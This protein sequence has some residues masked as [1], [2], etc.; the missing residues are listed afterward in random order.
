MGTV[1]DRND[2][3]ETA[4]KAGIRLFNVKQPT[5]IIPTTDVN[6][7]TNTITSAAHGLSAGDAIYYDNGGGGVMT[8]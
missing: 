5:L 4:D 8:N 6:T 7:G 2:S 3:T 1:A